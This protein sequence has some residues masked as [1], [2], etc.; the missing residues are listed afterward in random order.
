MST[1]LD[2]ESPAASL[3]VDSPLATAAEGV[4][5]VA[6]ADGLTFASTAGAALHPVIASTDTAKIP[7]SLRMRSSNHGPARQ[8]I[9]RASPATCGSVKL[10]V[11][12]EKRA[13]PDLDRELKQLATDQQR[14]LRQG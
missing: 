10:R 6:E 14:G 12:I 11:S 8:V 5:V 13:D 4:A 7:Q 3:H 9:F 1:A 2:L